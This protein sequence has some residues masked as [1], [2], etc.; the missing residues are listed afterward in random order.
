LDNDGNLICFKTGEAFDIIVEKLPIANQVTI[1]RQCD[2]DSQL[3]NDSQ[4]KI[5]PFDTTGIQETL[6][7]GQTDV[8][9]YY[10]DENDLFIGNNLPAIYETGPQKGKF[11]LGNH[12]QADYLHRIVLQL[13]PDLQ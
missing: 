4:D 11:Y 2:G 13:L 3:D 7:N 9:T 1:A 10:Y 12:C 8:T 6:L 5:F